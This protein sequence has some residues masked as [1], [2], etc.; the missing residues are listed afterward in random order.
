MGKKFTLS[1]LVFA[2]TLLALPIQAQT[3]LTA[4]KAIVSKTM[5]GVKSHE[6]KKV[7]SFASLRKAKTLKEAVEL[8]K[9]KSEKEAEIGQVEFAKLWDRNLERVADKAREGRSL[10]VSGFAYA[11]RFVAGASNRLTSRRAETVDVHGIITAPADGVTKVYTNAG[12]GVGTADDGTLVQVDQAGTSTFI[13]EAADGSVYIKDVVSIFN[14]GAWV[15]GT[16]N[17]N[18]ITVPAHQPVVYNSQYD[19]TVSVRWAKLSGNKYVPADDTSDHFTFV[20]DDAAGTISLQETSQ[21]LFMALLWDDDDTFVG[22]VWNT[23]Y[24]YDHDYV[25]PT[26]VTVTPPAGLQTENW[27]AEGHNVVSQNLNEY[28]TT[29]KVGFDGNDVYLQG[30]FE[31][32]PNAW[33]KGTINGS[34]VTFSDLQYQGDYSSTTPIYAVGTDNSALVDFV[35]TYDSEQKVLTSVNHLLANAATDRIYYLEWIDDIKIKKDAPAPVVVDELPYNNAISTSQEFKQFKVIDANQDAKTW[36][37]DSSNEA[38]SYSYHS[39]NEADDWL[40]SPAIKLEA[41]KFYR[42]ALDVRCLGYVERFEVKLGKEISAEALTQ[43]VIPAT[44]ITSKSFAT[45]ESLQVSVPETGYYYIGVHAISDADQ[46]KLLVSNFV[47]ENGLDPAAPAAVT[48]F[49]VIPTDNQ[50]EATVSFK[51]PAVTAGGETLTSLT[52]VEILRD[53]AVIATLTD[54]EPGAAVQYVDNAADLTMGSHTYQV[55]A[56]NEAGAGVKSEEKTVSLSA[57]LTVPYSFDL[58]SA[59]VFSFFTVIDANGDGKTWNWSESNGTNYSYSSDN[60]ADDYL[61]TPAIKL[62]AGKNYNV[63][64]NIKSSSDNYPEEFSV[65]VG[66]TATVEGLNKVVI[67]PTTVANT[68]PADFEGSFSVEEEGEYFIAVKASSEPDQWRLVVNTLSIEKGAEPT[69]P[70]AVENLNAISGLKGA[71]WALLTFNAPSKAVNGS[72][73][74]ENVSIDVLRDGQVIST[75]ENVAPGESKSYR[76]ADAAEG[77][78]TYQVIASNASGAGLKSN[79]VTVFVGLDA[80]APVNEVSVVDLQNKIEL[81]WEPVGSKGANGGYVDPAEVDYLVYNVEYEEFLGMVFPVRGEL[82]DS[83]RNS[84]YS[85]FDYNTNEGEQGAI[86]FLVVTKNA[87]GEG[88]ETAA[89][90]WVGAPYELP[91]AENFD[92]RTFHSAFDSDNI[93]LL[94]STDASDEDGVALLTK[95]DVATGEAFLSTG[96][97]SL[98]SAANPTLLFDVKNYATASTLSIVA[99]KANGTFVTLKDNVGGNAN[100]YTT[101]KVPLASIKDSYNRFYF[102]FNFGNLEDSILIDNIKIVDLYEHDLEVALSAPAAVV[103]GNTAKLKVNVANNAENAA[104]GFTLKLTANDQEIYNKTFNE[105]LKSFSSIDVDA[106]FKTT[107]FDEA[108]DVTLKAEVIYANDLKDDN[109]TDEAVITVKEPSVAAPTDLVALQANDSTVT[110]SWNAPAEGGAAEVTESFEDQSTFVPF[111]LGGVSESQRTGAFG[112]WTLYDGNGLHVYGFQNA[113]FENTS[114]VQAWQVFNPALAGT[115]F[116]SAYAAHSGEQFLWSFSPADEDEVGNTL[117]PNADH[118]LISPELPGVAQTISFFARAITDEYGAET[119]E[120]LASSTDNNPQNFSIVGSAYSTTATEWTEFTAELPA[121][122]KYFAIRHTSKDI[123]GL[124]VDDISYSVGGAAVSSFNI[125]V[126]AAAVSNTADKT[127]ELK[128]LAVGSHVFAV[129]AVYANGA[130]SKPVTATLDVVNAINEILNSGKSFTIYTVD[131]KLINRQAT[132]L[133]D[134]K[135]AYIINNKKVILK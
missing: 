17:G 41:G 56:Y 69:A 95:A 131:G 24:T 115:N 57:L 107:V 88:G 13:V 118:W 40:V 43:S 8:A 52:K 82:L 94:V 73:L 92:G 61:I 38:A 97:I 49:D 135:G 114:E 125:Y 98:K 126:D 96:K 39:T 81:S 51:A 86:N 85:Q 11:P 47:V 23:V 5:L 46:Y 102:N 111:S 27:Y 124:L 101:V 3:T 4:K 104:N 103:A 35:M 132:S 62:E 21:D 68:N 1:L 7:A 26:I 16:K 72:A 25:A 12:Q 108:R 79:K 128:N 90:V 54:V 74:T 123:F 83:V 32:F 19:A 80:P 42:V 77:F 120:V 65:L 30:L 117:V 34:T 93:R 10:A 121:G 31:N 113:T 71:K 119:F 6:L 50:I 112:D 91:W 110:L 14:I 116:A 59:D 60:Q 106:E 53:K 89:S 44:D 64:A 2:A 48:D 84:T 129:T 9:L 22:G 99:Q 66:K 45:Y 63:I 75:I 58:S 78:N 122:T 36:T 130:E 33:I 127:A 37:F 70:A 76:D 105:A 109:N 55:I 134:L 100:E 15:K 18:T 67:A 133:K 28:E 29:V 87:V 20:V